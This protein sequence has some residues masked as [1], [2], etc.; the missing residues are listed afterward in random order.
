MISGL[1]LAIIIEGLLSGTDLNPLNTAIERVI[2]GIRTPILTSLVVVITEMANP[3][4]F[5]CVSIFISVLLILKKNRYE[6]AIFLVAMI[7]ATLSFTIL[8]NIFQITRPVSDIYRIEGWVFPSGHA[9]IATTFFFMLAHIFWRRMR[10]VRSRVILV[11]G[12][13]IGILLVCFSR[14]YLGA[15]WTLDVMA[16]IAV[17][18]M[19]VSLTILVFNVFISPRRSV[20]KIIDL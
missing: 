16:G 20:R 10:T 5:A 4:V 17:G 3:F 9:T 7:V 6:A 11:L 15:H 13:V 2:V 1:I 14:L 8:K 19:S 18:L 12:S